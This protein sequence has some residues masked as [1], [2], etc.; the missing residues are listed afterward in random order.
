MEPKKA[1][2]TKESDPKPIKANEMSCI[3][4]YLINK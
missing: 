2:G 4:V 3:D 1:R